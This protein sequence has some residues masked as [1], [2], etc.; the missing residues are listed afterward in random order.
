MFEFEDTMGKA[1]DLTIVV[2]LVRQKLAYAHNKVLST[3]AAKGVS[4]YFF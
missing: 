4:S 3:I 1:K 2:V